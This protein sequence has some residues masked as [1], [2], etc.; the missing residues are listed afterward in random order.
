[1]G[2][3]RIRVAMLAALLTEAAAAGAG[4]SF[5]AGP[6]SF[7]D[8]LGGFTIRSVS[9]EG[10]RE[11][12][13]V[14]VEELHSASPVTLVIRAFGP[15]APLAWSG[16]GTHGR[17]HL[18]IIA[19][20]GSG[21]AWTEFEFELQETR[22]R[23]SLFGDGLSFDQPGGDAGLFGADRFR[24]HERQFEPHDRLLFFDGAVDPSI[25]ASFGL[26][27]SDITPVAEFYLLQDPRI[28]AS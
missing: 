27:I 20:N 21:H 2:G 25:P 19:F 11:R 3:T 18:R 17:F 24:R 7:S 6:F 8:E 5:R 16:D 23:P 9:G 28:P 15:V 13:V 4:G 10:T 22:G 12:P 1:M 26:V 14:L